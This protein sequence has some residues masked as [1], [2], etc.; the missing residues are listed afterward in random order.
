MTRYSQMMEH[1]AQIT[2]H[3]SLVICL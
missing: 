3:G 2:G 1:C